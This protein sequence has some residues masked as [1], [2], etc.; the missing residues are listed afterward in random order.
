MRVIRS[1]IKYELWYFAHVP[2]YLAIILA[3][4]H[5]TKSGDMS[6]GTAAA[7]WLFLT[8]AVFGIV[9]VYR[10]IRPALAFYRHQFR[11]E[12]IV[13]EADGVYSVYLTGK[14]ISQFIFNLRTDN[15]HRDYACQ[16][17]HDDCNGR[18]CHIVPTILKL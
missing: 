18:L 4:D 13:T 15:A 14:N 12:S 7:Y 16:N 11:V 9:I 6:R 8:Y 5:Q 17:N 2:L 1:K 10:F 3:F